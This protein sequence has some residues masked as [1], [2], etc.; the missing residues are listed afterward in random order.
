ML[1]NISK[2]MTRGGNKVILITGG[3]GYIGS[4]TALVLL[5]AGF[6]III[7]DN[8]SNSER[9]VIDKIERLSKRK[10]TF[11]KLD[12]TDKESIDYLFANYNIEGVMHFAG[13][14]AVA[15]SVREPLKYYYNNVLST[16]LLA[17][18]CIDNDV[19]KFIFSS[20][21]TV[22]GDNAVPFKEDM[23][24]GA[25]AN[26]YGESKLMSER[27]LTDTVKANELFAV[28]LLRYFNPIGAHASGLL[29]ESI[30]GDPNNLMPLILKVATGEL[31]ELTIFGDDYA[32]I[33]GTG[34]RDYIHVMDLARGHLLAY[35]KLKSGIEIYNL[36][37][38][39]GTS[40]LE[41]I[42]TFEKTNNINIPYKIGNRREGDLAEYYAD[43]SKAR[44]ALLFKAEKTLEDM[45]KDS[46][47]HVVLNHY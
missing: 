26:P 45:L 2:K 34:V 14:K 36:G 31:K 9:S 42:N 43:V 28:S 20:S 30:H 35:Q 7:V 6:D 12:V 3:A 10:F 8:L 32:T 11:Y 39:R 1:N 27:V 21:A 46:W 41:L 37:T 5:E 25:R 33:D 4:H 38:G 22:Y 44:S 13:Y 47:R 29:G 40:V 15:E 23:E 17:K 18:A 16:I 24:L 19:K